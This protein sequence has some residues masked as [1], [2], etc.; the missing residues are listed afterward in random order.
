MQIFRVFTKIFLRKN[1]KNSA[2]LCL[3]LFAELNTTYSFSLSRYSP[4]GFKMKNKIEENF[5][6][7]KFRHFAAQNQAM[8][9]AFLNHFLKRFKAYFNT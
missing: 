2:P 6:L 9:L 8:K 4:Y 1:S 5:F 7:W 3:L